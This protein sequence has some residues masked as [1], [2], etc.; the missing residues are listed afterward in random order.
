MKLGIEKPITNY[1]LKRSGV[2]LRRL[3]GDSDSV[4]QHIAGWT[5]TKQLKTYDLTVHDD[6]FRIE[7]AKR[8]IVNDPQHQV[9][10]PKTRQCPFCKTKNGLYLRHLSP[11]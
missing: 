2:T 1:S 11:T 3:R 4:I 8:G 5:S 7:L 10:S 9:Y 6:I